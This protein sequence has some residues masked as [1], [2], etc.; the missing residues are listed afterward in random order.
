MQESYK[1]QDEALSTLDNLQDPASGA[2]PVG[3]EEAKRPPNPHDDCDCDGVCRE[4][5]DDRLPEEIKVST[6]QNE[7]ITLAT[8]RFKVWPSKLENGAK[9]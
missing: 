2:P 5:H 3:I 1:F 8:K 4:L 7:I 9:I 6:K